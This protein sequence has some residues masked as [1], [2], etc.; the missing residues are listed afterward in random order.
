M[1][2]GDDARASERVGGGR[3]ARR[4]QALRAAR[5]RRS[6]SSPSTG[7]RR[8]CGRRPWLFTDELEWSQ[9]SR[10]IATTGRA[11]RRGQP[12][13]FDSLYSYLIA[14]AWWIHSTADAYA[15]IKY[16]NVVV[17]CLT[18]VPVYLLGA[19][20]ARAAAV[21]RRR[22]ALDRDPGD[23]VHELDRPGV[24]R[25]SVVRARG[26]VRR[27]VPRGAE[28][29]P[30]RACCRCSP[31]AGLWVRSEFVALP[32]SL[33]LASAIVLTWKQG[34]SLSWRR[35]WRWIALT[36]VGLV[37]VRV[38][39]QPPRRR[40]RPAAGSSASTSTRTRCARAGSPRVRSRSGSGCC[41]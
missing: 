26:A 17:M 38:P 16:L 5:P 1:P 10:A 4:S 2:A 33:V 6:S 39:L 9:L 13:S 25:L 19:D 8:R 24:A 3:A 32:A 28:R 20:A 12:H 30:G 11:A 31:S 27:P 23:V 40:A 18:A 21:A 22:A 36:A 14:P 35:R 34:G 15:A 7:S 41:R 37:G 29:R